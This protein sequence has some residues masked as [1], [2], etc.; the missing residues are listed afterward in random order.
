MTTPLSQAVLKDPR[1]GTE[2]PACN[3]WKDQAVLVVVLRR[4]GC[5]E[6]WAA[7][8]VLGVVR[9]RNAAHWPTGPWHPSLLLAALLSGDSLASNRPR[10]AARLPALQCCAARRRWRCGLRGRSLSSSTSGWSACSTS[11]EQ[12]QLSSSL[13]QRRPGGQPVGPSSWELAGCQPLPCMPAQ[14]GARGGGICACILGRR[15]V[16]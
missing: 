15:A 5:R 1:A 9:R 6:W 11:G 3:L 16:L 12:W 10:N 8:S 4:P 13:R 7:C 2:V 14:E